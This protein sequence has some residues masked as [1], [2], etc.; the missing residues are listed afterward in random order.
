MARAFAAYAD[1]QDITIFAAGVSN[2]RE[3]EPAAFDREA[4]LLAAALVDTPGLIVYFGSCSQFDPSLAESQYVRHK[5]AME[6]MIAASGRPWRVFRLPQVVGRS[7]NPNTLVNFIAGNLREGR[8]FEV[9]TNASRALIEAADLAP[10]A[11]HLLAT[12]GPSR[13]VNFWPAPASPLDITRALEKILG[14]EGDYDIV[15][16]GAPFDVEAAEFHAAASA[17]GIDVGRGYFESVLRNV[18]GAE[19]PGQY[20]SR[21]AGLP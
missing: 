1:A 2:A 21:G 17:V 9:W 7:D 10:I 5:R 8:R 3:T 13:A 4:A 11:A 14:V 12:G 16:K 15:S 20:L 18:Y 19:Q 6:E